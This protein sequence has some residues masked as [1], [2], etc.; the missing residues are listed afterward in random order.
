MRKILV[1]SALPYANGAIH[2]GHLLEY[3]QS[4]IWVRALRLSGHSCYHVCADD[5]HGTAVMISAERAGVS[6]EAWIGQMRAEHERDLRAFGVDFDIYSSTHTECTRAISEN[7]YSTLLQAGHISTHEL[8]QLF[9]PEKQMFLADRYIKGR[10]PSCQSP[11]QYGDN[12]EVCGATYN[13]TQLI[14]PYSVLSGARPVLKKSLH[15]FF[16]LPDFTDFLQGWLA[17]AQLQPEVRNKLQEWF[18]GGLK[19]WDISRDAPY[20]GFR[21][22]D[23]EDKYFYVWLDAPIGYAGAFRE[24]CSQRDLDFSSYWQPDSAT[25]LYHF[26]GKDIIYFHGLFW[27]AMLHGAGWRTP[28]A[29]FAHGFLTVNA[30]KL[31]KSKGT[32]INARAY[33]DELNPEYLRYYFAS[34]LTSKVEDIDFNSEDFVERCNSDLVGKLVNIASRC[35][36]FLE[37]DYGGKLA[38]EL[39]AEQQQLI[40][41]SASAHATIA[42]LYEAREYAKLVRQ[43]MQW[44]DETNQYIDAQQPWKKARDPEQAHLVQAI[45]STGVNAFRNLIVYLKPI[46]PELARSSEAFL[47]LPEQRFA[48]VQSPLLDHKLAPFSA[49]ITRIDAKSINKLLGL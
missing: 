19:E 5:A 20:F 45:C 48:D 12:C 24:L 31:S 42:E 47:Q 8:E 41:R 6:P 40:A 4:D 1:T 29:I 11:D 34:K 14:E 39:N 46:L 23:S 33:L 22:P 15:Y 13:A 17:D 25:E 21:I 28:D 36:R 3:I 9:D 38:P 35:A 26:I 32:A 7:I 49:L 16:K 30:N 37:R 27:P 2:I 43:V 18:A 10:C 44:A